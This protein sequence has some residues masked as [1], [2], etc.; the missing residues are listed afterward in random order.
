MSTFQETVQTMIDRGATV[1]SNFAQSAQGTAARAQVKLKITDLSLERDKLM[2]E[3]GEAV[4]ASATSD[5]A[6]RAE[7]AGLFEKL[8]DVTAH[9][10]ALE[11]ELVRM[12]GKAPAGDDARGEGE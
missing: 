11:D 9:K 12:G 8:D 4:Y 6:V 10:E 1:V 2:K 3:L 7:H 5:A